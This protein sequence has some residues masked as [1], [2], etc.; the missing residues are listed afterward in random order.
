MIN[1]NAANS[2]LLTRGSG[3]MVGSLTL[4]FDKGGL[5]LR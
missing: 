4:Y 3:D 1:I 2:P 5:S